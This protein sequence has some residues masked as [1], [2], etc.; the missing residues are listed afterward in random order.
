MVNVYCMFKGK[1]QC[2]APYFDEYGGDPHYVITVSGADANSFNI[3]V[4]SESKVTVH[5]EDHRVSSN[6]DLNFDEPIACI[7][8]I[9]ASLRYI[10]YNI[11]APYYFVVCKPQEIRPDNFCLSSN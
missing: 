5:G 6:L 8:G 7:G 3:V 9:F 1:L 11:V 10:G 4:N 2:A